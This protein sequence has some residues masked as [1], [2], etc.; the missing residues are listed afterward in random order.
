MVTTTGKVSSSLMRTK[1]KKTVRKES[2]F[3]NKRNTKKALKTCG[4]VSLWSF[5]IFYSFDFLAGISNL[6]LVPW[7]KGFGLGM[8][9]LVA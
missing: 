4:L 7:L 2:G 6:F 8:L 9:S 5:F 3:W 1:V